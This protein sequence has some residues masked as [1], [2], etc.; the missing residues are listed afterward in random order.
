M[1]N[2]IFHIAIDRNWY[3]TL[4]AACTTT[5]RMDAEMEP[6]VSSCICDYYDDDTY[7]YCPSYFHRISFDAVDDRETHVKIEMNVPNHGAR[8]TTERIYEVYEFDFAPSTDD[9]DIEIFRPHVHLF[10]IL[11]MSTKM[12]ATLTDVVGR[13]RTKRFGADAAN[14]EVKSVSEMIYENIVSMFSAKSIK[15]TDIRWIQ[16]VAKTLCHAIMLSSNIPVMKEDKGCAH[17]DRKKKHGR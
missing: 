1:S 12:R 9:S 13:M 5:P 11:F 3:G 7:C 8:Q 14:A 2:F 6:F 16:P 10:K 17:V 4:C 15:R